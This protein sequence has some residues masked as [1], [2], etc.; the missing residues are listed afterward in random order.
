MPT[1]VSELEVLVATSRWLHEN[2]WRIDSISLA[3]GSGLPRIA[4]QKEVVVQEYSA[5]HIPFDVR[6]LFRHHGPDIVAP[7]AQGSWKVECEGLSSADPRTHKNSFDRAVASVVSYY[8]DAS[9]TRLGLALADD[10]FWEYNYRDRVPLALR[11]ALNLWVFL[12]SGAGVFLA[13]QPDN[14]LPCPGWLD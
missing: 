10:F 4:R 2:S 8:D 3:T 9:E 12:V 11:K 13:Y 5:I 6:T 7:S 14:E 1:P